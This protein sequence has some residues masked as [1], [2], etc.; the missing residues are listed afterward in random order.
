MTKQTSP[1]EKG[2]WTLQKKILAVALTI[3]AVA[4]AWAALASGSDCIKKEFTGSVKKISAAVADTLDEK[5]WRAREPI[6]SAILSQLRS[7][8][9]DLRKSAYVA[10][11]TMT[12]ASWNR[13]QASWRS[14]SIRFFGSRQ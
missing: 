3:G 6:D 13:T 9:M 7:I 1:E 4:G 5:R 12:P 10:E 2:F 11:K 8:Q 14:D